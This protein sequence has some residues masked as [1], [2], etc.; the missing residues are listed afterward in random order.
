LNVSNALLLPVMGLRR[1]RRMK[2]EVG[3]TYVTR[4]G[5]KVNVL[6]I[7]VDGDYPVLGVMYVDDSI[8]SVEFTSDGSYDTHRTSLDCDLIREHIDPGEGYRILDPDEKVIKGDEWADGAEWRES[9]NHNNQCFSKQ[10]S[11]LTYRRK[12]T[13]EPKWVDVVPIVM[14][15]LYV[16][17]YGG[18]YVKLSQ[19]H[20][21]PE[22][23]GC[24]WDNEIDEEFLSASIALYRDRDGELSIEMYGG[25]KE[26]CKAV[27]FS[28]EE[29]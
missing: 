20:D 2:I 5:D 12:I 3:K 18:L 8:T 17:D 15:G 14:N 21:M 29:K 11:F 24:V 1:R 28:T 13:P 25:T 23:I 27:R 19:V 10:S 16:V 6:F 9:S 26:I 7:G 4:A 22:F